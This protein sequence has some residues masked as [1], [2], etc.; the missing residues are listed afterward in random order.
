MRVGAPELI[1]DLAD[2]AGHVA[3]SQW[4]DGSA[5]AITLQEGGN[6]DG[7][8]VLLRHSQ[9]QRGAETIA[10]LH[11][12]GAWATVALRRKRLAAQ[13]EMERARLETVIAEVP[14][15]VVLAEAPSGRVVSVNRKA[16]ELWGAPRIRR[17]P[18]RTTTSSRCFTQ[19]AN[20][21]G[22]T[23]VRLPA[24]FSRERSSREEEAQ[25]ERADGSRSIV[26]I[27]S[28]PIRDTRGVISAG[29][30]AIVDITDERK[31]EERARFLDDISRQLAATLDYDATIQAALQ[32]LVP[33]MADAASVHHR[34]G[35]ILVRRWE[36]S[37]TDAAFDRKLRELT[38]DYPLQLPSAHPVAVAVRTGKAQLHEV[39]DETLLKT[40]ARNG[41]GAPAA[42][43]SSDSVR[44]DAA[45]D[46]SREDH[47]CDA[48]CVH[49]GGSPILAHRSRAGR[50]GHSPR[51]ARDR[52]R[53]PVR[54]RQ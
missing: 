5:M 44:D 51:R 16:I 24:R 54:V 8:L 32:L 29:V 21:T 7:A 35:D 1:V 12:L 46:R 3:L 38:R 45:F 30:S 48:V 9:M 31:R 33:R 42:R 15:G 25:I 18:S 36:T 28:A 39:V 27:N 10:R 49:P 41:R 34:E 19:T 13:L 52:Q 2:Y 37:G 14:V 40:I 43:S 17:S 11:S 23:S 53:A 22:H 50:R 6:V 20:R 26:R 47:R 4:T